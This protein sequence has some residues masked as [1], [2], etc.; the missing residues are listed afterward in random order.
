MHGQIHIG[1]S[2]WNYKDWR[3]TVYPE[4]LAAKKWL[5]YY[6][7][8]F[9]TVEVNTTFYRFPK[10][11]FAAN[12]SSQVPPDFQFALKL[13]KGMTHY[14]KLT[15]C[16]QW[17]TDFGVVLRELPEPQR[18]PLL[19]Q[20]SPHHARDDARLDA[21]L[22]ELRGCAVPLPGYV[23]VEFRHDSWLTPEIYA[24]LDRHDVAICQH[25]MPARA[26]VSEPN[27]APL[28]YVRRHGPKGDYHGSY[29]PAP[30]EADAARIARWQQEGREVY[31]YFNNDYDGHAVRDAQYVISLLHAPGRG[32]LKSHAPGKT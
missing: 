24:V 13:W 9:D 21:F 19:I 1:T 30:L 27:D 5:A 10:P 15:Q 29:G 6:S 11:H 16:T 17:L 2:G 22:S 8:L 25:D 7:T 32:S 3:G 18:G 31:M 12:W 4:K 14:R 26:P 20:L 23:T 28:V